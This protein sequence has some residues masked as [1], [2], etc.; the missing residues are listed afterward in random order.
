MVGTGDSWRP[1]QPGQSHGG[2]RGWTKL[3]AWRAMGTE[4]RMVS[5][6]LALGCQGL[7]EL[8]LLYRNEEPSKVFE[9]KW[10][11]CYGRCRKMVLQAE[12]CL[13]N[14]HTKN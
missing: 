14:T 12:R 2:E 5:L 3:R 6:R 8:P 7:R 13:E 10:T 11:S 1:A 4:V 9:Q